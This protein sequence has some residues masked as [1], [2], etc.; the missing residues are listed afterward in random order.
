MGFILAGGLGQVMGQ[1]EANRPNIIFIL[2]DDQRWDDWG[3]A[4]NPIVHTPHLDQLAQDGIYFDQAY[5][6]SA[7][8]TPSR[9]SIFLGQYER[10]HSV[11]FTSGTALSPAAWAQSY[12]VLLQQAGYFTGYV[13]KNH[14]PIGTRGYQ[15][16]LMQSSFDYW[17]AAHGHL[18][19]Y[20]K[21]RHDIFSNADFD[22]QIEVV[23]QGAG[24]FLKP[25]SSFL[26]GAEQ[27]LVHLPEDRPFCL[28]IALNLPHA[29]GT[30]SMQLKPEDPALYR[31]QYRDLTL[32]FSPLYLPK[33]SIQ[34]PKLPPELLH[35]QYRQ[36]SYAYVNTPETLRETL[37]RRYQ[38]V[39]G[40]DRM[41]GQIQRLLA[42]QGLSE[43]TILV[44]TSDHGIMLGEWGLGGKA[45]NYENCLR[46]PLIIYDPRLPS[47]RKGLT[48]SALVQ[49]I[50]LAP[51]MLEW[52]G[53]A[54][55]ERM[56]GHSLVDLMTGAEQEVREVLFAENLWSNW[57]GNPRIES[58]RRGNWK[59]IRYFRNDF[60]APPKDR[61]PYE[62]YSDRAELYQNYRK[63]SIEGE[64]PLYEELFDLESDPGEEHNLALD[65]Q[66]QDLMAALR[67]I[68]QRE[69]TQAGGQEEPW[70]LPYTADLIKKWQE[71][72]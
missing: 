47:A 33:D 66:H 36:A 20:P 9:A 54:P 70:V 24:N 23:G 18:G 3:R 15:D 43:N 17:Y 39:T 61:S 49:T 60:G 14:V 12:P 59:Y 2:T 16:T 26:L 65:P 30:S 28:S 22:T 8:C 27:F 13:G 56:Q 46:V 21:E 37:I 64:E 32:P 35:T 4:G 34:A 58:V 52:A 41:L 7:I 67:E 57:F 44:I 62:V 51:T 40:I 55:G 38:T 68:C 69:V 10:R 42:E 48:L 72:K 31:T 50:D 63:S 29:N 45:L 11:N 6:S 25:D 1:A 71:E 5:V 53:L 19:F